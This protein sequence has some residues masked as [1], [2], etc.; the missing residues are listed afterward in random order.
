MGARDSIPEMFPGLSVGGGT[1]P[2]PGPLWAEALGTL[3]P[4]FPV[5]VHPRTTDHSGM[6]GWEGKGCH[7]QASGYPQALLWSLSLPFP[8]PE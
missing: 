1:P 7:L 4:A 8:G 6:A 2:F 5:R 3:S